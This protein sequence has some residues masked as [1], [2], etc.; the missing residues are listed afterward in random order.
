[1]DE[2]SP[3]EMMQ[4]LKEVTRTTGFVHEKQVYHIKMLAALV[5]PQKGSF[6][7]IV[8]PDKG[9][10][11]FQFKRLIEDGP[12]WFLG[13]D[14][15]VKWLLGGNWMI[16]VRNSKGETIYVSER[17]GDFRLPPEPKTEIPEDIT[18]WR[19]KLK[20]PN[21]SHNLQTE[22]PKRTGTSKKRKTTK[23]RRPR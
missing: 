5:S 1:M 7:V 6:Q 14:N 12:K 4:R 23:S 18:P 11:E 20:I 8:L 9:V 17:I 19:D 15:S 21:S 16:R 2:V 3:V 10:V 22:K 13:L